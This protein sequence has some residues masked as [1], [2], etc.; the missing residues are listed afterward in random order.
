ME[1]GQRPCALLVFQLP[2]VIE[3]SV[4]VSV[5]G[6][7]ARVE[8]AAAQ[9]GVVEEETA[10]EVVDG[11][12]GTGQELVGDECHVVAGLTEQLG[13]E[14]IVAPVALLPD[15]VHGEDVLEAEAGEVPWR[16][17]V[18]VFRQQSRPFQCRLPW[19]GLHCVAVLARVVTAE[20]LAN[21]EHYVW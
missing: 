13:E 14:R 7:V 9:Y 3:Q 11:L 12:L 2:V 16:H 5:N 15:D 10:A 8:H 4:V 19:C 6:G 17:H 21:D 20:A 1:D 18:G